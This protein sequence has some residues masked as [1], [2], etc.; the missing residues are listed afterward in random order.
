M[1]P[2]ARAIYELHFRVAFLEK[3]GEAFQDFFSTL[4]ELAH[5]ADFQRVRPSGRLGDWKNDGYLRSERTLFQVYAPRQWPAAEA[6]RKIEEDFTGALKHWKE[7]LSTWAFVHNAPDGLVAPVFKKL[8]DLQAANPQ[9]QVTSWGR[10]ELRAR[11]SRLSEAHLTQ[12]FGPVPTARSV[13]ALGIA[14]L[15]PVLEQ[16]P[17]LPAP[18]DADL[19]P[20]P[21]DK[22]ELNLLSEHAAAMLKMGMRRATLVGRYFDLR[23]N[24]TERD[25]V[26][27]ALR[28]KYEELRRAGASP[29]DVFVGLQNF[30]DPGRMHSIER[31]AAVFTVLAYFFEECDIFERAPRKAEP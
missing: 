11:L 25:A 5:P 29:D 14:D 16:I 9:V 7:H 28:V 4:M 10:E 20:V 26:A 12:L 17:R 8:Q 22:I 24:P 23:P 19:R 3:K 30:V 13:D 27:Q 21:A 18:A 15:R 1:D 31:Q 2:N 6:V